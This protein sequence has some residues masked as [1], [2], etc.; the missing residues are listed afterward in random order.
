MIADRCCQGS[1]TLRRPSSSAALTPGDPRAELPWTFLAGI[2][3]DDYRRRMASLSATDPPPAKPLLRGVLHQGAFI[4]SVVVGTLLIVGSDGGAERVA[5]AIFAGSV[6]ACFGL[7]ALYHRVNWAPRV[8][9]W[10]RRADH[11]GVYLLIAGTYT[12][13]C[14]IAL[15][16]NLR[17]VVLAIVAAGAGAAIIM[18]V[19]WVEAP[20]WLAAVIG[21]GLGWV[22]VALLPELA[23][24]VSPAAIAL[25]CLGGIAYTVGAVV[26]ALRRP[27]PAPTTFGFHELFHALTIVG[28][29]CQYVAIAFFVIRAG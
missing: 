19:A 14:V 8:R 25:L 21:L 23:T 17:L 1:T 6:A 27:N 3:S 4:V 7:S 9:L 22:G 26:Y 29:S 16:G 18:K 12:P 2:A 11:A 5:A 10:M 15:G 28:V 13:V 24:H 20:T